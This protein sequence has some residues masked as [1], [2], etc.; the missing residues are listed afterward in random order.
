MTLFI[1]AVILGGAL[2][3]FALSFLI[4]KRKLGK[5]DLLK[6]LTGV[7]DWRIRL[8]GLTD[9]FVAIG[10]EPLLA[11]AASKSNDPAQTKLKGQTLALYLQ[12]KDYFVSMSYAYSCGS[13]AVQQAEGLFKPKGAL[14]LANVRR[15]TKLA[16]QGLTIK[17]I[18]PERYLNLATPANYAPKPPVYQLAYILEVCDRL[19]AEITKGLRSIAECPP[20][21]TAR[22]AAAGTNLTAATELYSTL[23]AAGVTYLPYEQRQA[24]ID[25]VQLR[26][27]SLIEVDPLGALALCNDL[28]KLIKAL[29]QELDQARQNLVEVGSYEQKLAATRQW[30][31]NVRATPVTCP[32]S[33]S[34]AATACWTLSNPDSDPD[35]QLAQSATLLTQARQSLANGQLP[36]VSGECKQALAARVQAEKMVKALIDAKTAVDEQI[37][38]VRAELVTIHSELVGITGGETT[39]EMAQLV[40]R[41]CTAVEGRITE[42]YALYVKQLFAEA[43][44]LLT[45]TAGTEY[46]LPVAKLLAQAKELLELLKKA[47]QVARSLAKQA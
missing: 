38:R 47:A 46:G 21:V 18:T 6:G 29:S 2:V 44:T 22:L 8:N 42:V 36:A 9:R 33:D 12:L 3:L 27:G 13:R 34:T 10:A 43:L 19:A 40:E 35:S 15:A 11:R 1:F 26:V 20:K 39:H 14:K 5:D 41:V 17:E 7:K 4:D 32:W 24:A 16:E 28:D 37:P 31:A 25:A 23:L 45:G 30:I